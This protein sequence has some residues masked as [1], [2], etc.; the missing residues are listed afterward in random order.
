MFN[1]VFGA[2]RANVVVPF[3]SRPKAAPAPKG[4]GQDEIAEA[5]RVI[6]ILARG[7]LAV[8]LVS[9]LSDEGHPW[10]AVL[11]DDNEDVV[12]HFARIDGRVILASAASEKVFSGPSL[13]AALR[14]VLETQPLILPPGDRSLF[15]HPATI[16]AAFIATALINSVSDA[17]TAPADGA[18]DVQARMTHEAA[19]AGARQGEGG[20][21]MAL[22]AAA[23]A[24][25][26]TALSLTM[27]EVSLYGEE[28]LLELSAMQTHAE[29]APGLHFAFKQIDWDGVSDDPL[30]VLQHALRGLDTWARV[31]PEPIIAIDPDQADPAGA[32]HA[33]MAYEEMS[34][35]LDPSAWHL[36][37]IGEEAAE[38]LA[39][40]PLMVED[41]GLLAVSLLQEETANHGASTDSKLAV[42]SLAAHPGFIQANGEDFYWEARFLFGMASPSESPSLWEASAKTLRSEDLQLA[43][44]GELH[45]FPTDTAAVVTVARDVAPDVKAT[46]LKDFALDHGKELAADPGVLGQVLAA[47]K[48]LPLMA[49]VDRVVVFEADDVRTD[50]FMMFKG[51]AMVRGDMLGEDL[52]AL[53]LPQQ[54]AFEMTNG[55]YFTLLGVIDV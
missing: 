22:V 43:N 33:L 24:S 37:G 50:A 19:T 38:P 3:M 26:A 39:S 40:A 27:D 18:R 45:T 16:L 36:A 35:K 34:I 28:P 13:A 12:V 47:L 41:G 1:S 5:Y 20:Y 7:G 48:A 10:A 4:W 32:L 14:S 9:G 30:G 29:H 17:T 55:E 15:L 53:A 6:D 42:T 46:I 31:R 8:H 2:A 11:R 51:V 25:V 49:E 54:V 21:S 52:Q 44:D 23:V